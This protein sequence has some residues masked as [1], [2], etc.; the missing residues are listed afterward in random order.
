MNIQQ[1]LVISSIVAL[2]YVILTFNNNHGIQTEWELNNEAIISCTGIGQSILDEIELRAFDEKTIAK[3]I[4]T[5]DSLTPSSLL[6]KDSGETSHYTFDD[7][8]DYNGYTQIDSLS[9]LG[10]FTTSIE[11]Y[12]VNTMFP[13][14]K[15]FNKSFSKRI[16]IYVTNEY[17]IKPVLFSKVLSY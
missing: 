17:L 3:T 2:T 11:V 15:I 4:T 13:D 5:T 16:N 14:T 9:R 10:V 12:Y 7:I 8:D 6:R 1:F